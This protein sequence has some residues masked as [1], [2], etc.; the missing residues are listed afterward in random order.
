MQNITFKSKDFYLVAVCL[1]FGCSLKSIS[2]NI[3]NISEFELQQ[4]S[5]TCEKI[6]SKHWTGELMVSSLKLIESINQLKTRL[7]SGF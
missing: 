1:A 7:H 3:N 6:I 4:T 5:E 2:R